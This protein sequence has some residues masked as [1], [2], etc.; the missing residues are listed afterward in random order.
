MWMWGSK[1]RITA[2]QDSAIRQRSLGRAPPLVD[3]VSQLRD[4]GVQLLGWRLSVDELPHFGRGIPARRHP[5]VNVVREHARELGGYAF[6]DALK[7]GD[8]DLQEHALEDG[9]RKRRIVEV[10]EGVGTERC[11]NQPGVVGPYGVLYQ[12]RGRVTHRQERQR[13]QQ[14]AALGGIALAIKIIEFFSPPP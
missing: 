8:R 13:P 1:I 2:P 3:G 5:L 7:G 4:D 10:L 6:V 12:R 11:G 14:P 9:L